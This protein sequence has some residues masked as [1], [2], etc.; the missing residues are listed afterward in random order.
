MDNLMFSNSFD[1]N[2]VNNRGIRGGRFLPIRYYTK[3]LEIFNE[4]AN[5]S[6][7]AQNTTEVEK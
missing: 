3:T 7:D 6:R 5:K 2:R 4:P 1:N